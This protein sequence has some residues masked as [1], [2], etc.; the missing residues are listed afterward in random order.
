MPTTVKYQKYVVARPGAEATVS[1]PADGGADGKGAGSGAPRGRELCAAPLAVNALT[2]LIGMRRA[3]GPSRLHSASTVGDHDAC[4]CIHRNGYA[5]IWCHTSGRRPC[6]I[7]ESTALGSALL[8][9]AREINIA[10]DDTGACRVCLRTR[11]RGKAR[12]LESIHAT[13]ADAAALVAR[14]RGNRSLQIAARAAETADADHS[15]TALTS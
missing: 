5:E 2:A 4:D 8:R 7:A 15:R 6:R 14:T 9:D 10:I 13:R 12:A 1:R 3:G 11:I